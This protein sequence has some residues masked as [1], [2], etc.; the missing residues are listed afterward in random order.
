MNALLIIDVQND[1]CAA[2]KL[3]VHNGDKVIRPI[4]QVIPKF[5]HIIQT[6]DWHP[7]DHL[8]FASN[9][10]GKSE[11]EQIVLPYGEQVLW[12]DHCVQGTKGADFH[13]ELNT[14]HTQL[15]IRKGFRKEIDSYS[16]FFENDKTTSTG[17]H[18]FLSSLGIKRVFMCG[19]ATDFCVKYSAL[20]ARKLSYDV[21]LLTDA[22]QA[23]D[24]NNS[25]DSALAEMKAAG[26]DFISSGEID[27]AL[28]G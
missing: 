12:P 17:L 3:A 20:D 4:N 6:Q 27:S 2:G 28:N 5:E 19:L 21:T 9:H 26:V 23:I 24:L 13:P 14:L 25:K 16:A 1:F 22:V 11:Y 15:V 8:S 10:E 7:K 18:G